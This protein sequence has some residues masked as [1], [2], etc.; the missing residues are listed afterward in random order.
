MRLTLSVLLHQLELA[1]HNYPRQVV[2]TLA[3]DSSAAANQQS[4]KRASS[5][6][7]GEQ[8]EPA[9]RWSVKFDALLHARVLDAGLARTFAAR[10]AVRRRV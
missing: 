4:S 5:A 1:A 9:V 8:C 6:V 10:R 2:G 7:R 3:V